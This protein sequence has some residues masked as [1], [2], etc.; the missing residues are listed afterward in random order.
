M[1]WF[2]DL[3]EILLCEQFWMTLEAARKSLLQHIG[4]TA[5]FSLKVLFDW[6][7]AFSDDNCV[8][9]GC[10]SINLGGWIAPIPGF[11]RLLG[12]FGKNQAFDLSTGRRLCLGKFLLVGLLLAHTTTIDTKDAIGSILVE[13]RSIFALLGSVVGAIRQ[14]IRRRP[15]DSTT[16]LST[17]NDRQCTQ[18]FTNM[19]I[20][21][22][23]KR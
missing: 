15:A 19:S 22:L 23:F 21:V 5:A 18:Y 9:Q 2:L 13:G 20:R 6:S 1:R 7:N 4:S 8:H 12:R 3:G 10:H 17:P 16:A 14:K 11:R